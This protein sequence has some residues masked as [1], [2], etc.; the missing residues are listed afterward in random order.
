VES[1]KRSQG[2]GRP[3]LGD[4]AAERGLG[5]TGLDEE[6]RMGG[7]AKTKPG[8]GPTGLDDEGRGWVDS[9]KTKPSASCFCAVIFHSLRCICL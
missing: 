6:G 8:L 7:I 5:P 3:D 4:P 9:E 2:P 1:Q